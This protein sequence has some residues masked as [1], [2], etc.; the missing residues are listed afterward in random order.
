MVED[1]QSHVCPLW[2][3]DGLLELPSVAKAKGIWGEMQKYGED[4]HCEDLMKMKGMAITRKRRDTRDASVDEIRYAKHFWKI[5]HEELCVLQVT[6]YNSVIYKGEVYK[7]GND[8]VV[9]VDQDHDQPH[10]T[11]GH[12]KAHITSF[13][14]MQYK[15]NWMLFFGAEY[16]RQC[17]VGDENEEYLRIDAITGMSVLE[18]QR[19]PFN[20]DSIRPISSLLHKFYP[21]VLPLEQKLIAY[22]IKDLK[23]RSRLLED[24][25]VGN[26][27]PWLEVNDVVKAIRNLSEIH[28]LYYAVVRD[29]NHH[30]KEVRLAFLKCDER[31]QNYLKVE[32]EENFWRGWNFCVK[33]VL[34]WDVVRSHRVIHEGKETW[35]PIKWKSRF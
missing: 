19:L 7:V 11:I 8:V 12:W 4:C 13:F 32:E 15:Q 10:H 26:V 14:S 27:P 34:H 6:C 22:E 17:A 28:I 2:H 35:Y 21:L 23:P 18:K 30:S 33:Q 24:G 3:K 20:W 5:D 25:H 31:N 29:V 9:E 16:Y 1:N